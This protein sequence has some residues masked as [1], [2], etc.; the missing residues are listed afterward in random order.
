MHSHTESGKILLMKLKPECVACLK[1]QIDHII[2]ML[3]LTR[4]QKKAA[5]K[6]TE[7]FLVRADYDGCTP[8]AMAEI[9]KILLSY[10]SEDDPYAKIKSLC[11]R[12]AA[13]LVPTIREKLARAADPFHVI[14]KYAAAGNL[15]D[16]SLE[17]PVPLEEQNEQ[18]D[19]IAKNALAIDD[20]EKLK[21][22][23]SCAKNLLYL[24]DN[25]GEIVFDTLLIECIQ[26]DYPHL[27][28][29]FAVKGMPVLN[30]VTLKDAQEVGMDRLAR[31]I[32]NG[33]G[34]PGTLLS[35]AS[36]EFRR[37]FYQAD[38][39]LS[40]G[41][42]NFESLGSEQRKNLFF[43]FTVKCD[44]VV[45]EARAPLGSIVCMENQF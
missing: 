5:V 18:I 4:T 3:R 1:V 2:D 39:I 44:A 17:N 41:Q 15:I 13:K 29:T 43:L 14:L 28:V 9:W 26:A 24:G 6:E 38:M 45:Q 37:E 22:A 7:A 42:G 40:K 8:A 16:Y 36:E 12:E 19:A 21:A 34:S 25:A 20:S 11:N 35:R 10:T 33:D 31:I 27:Q 32:D 30:D 23:M